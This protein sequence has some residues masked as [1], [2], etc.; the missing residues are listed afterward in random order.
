MMRLTLVWLTMGIVWLCAPH[1]LAQTDTEL[2]VQERVRQLVDEVRMAA[3]P[4]LQRVEIKIQLFDSPS[5]Y[6]QTRFTFTSF[7]FQAKLRYV[8]RVNRRLFA[9]PAPDEALRAVIAHELAHIL[10]FKA[11]PQLQLLSLVRLVS[12]DFTAGFERRTD[13]QALARHYGPGLKAYRQWLYQQ[14]PADKLAEKQ[15]NYFSP[16]EI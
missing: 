5:D 11:R 10:Y 9:Q 15:R 14:V 3:Y 16:A 13:L 1:A 4:E 7:L 6:F 12:P 2:A 8:L